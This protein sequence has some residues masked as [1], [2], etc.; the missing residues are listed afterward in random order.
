MSFKRLTTL[1]LMAFCFLTGTFAQRFIVTGTVESGK[2]NRGVEFVT[3]ALL[4]SDSTGVTSAMTNENGTFRLR[5]KSAGSYI[6][7]ISYVGFKTEYR[8]VVLTRQTDSINIGRIPLENSDNLLKEAVVSVTAARVEQQGDTT[9]F[10][11]S[12]Y[13]VPEGSTLEALVEQL[14]G[15]EVD[16][17]GTITWNGKE[18]KEFLVNGK[19]FFKGDTQVAMKNL[20]TDLVSKIKAYDKKSD[21]AEQTGIDDGEETTVLDITTKR[22]LK[23]SWISNVDLGVGTKDRYTDRIFIS[24]FTETSRISAYG[25]ANNVADRGFGSGRRG[26]GGGNGLTASKSAGMD[27]YW[28]NGKE[29]REA[30]RLELGGNVRYSH[31]GTDA[32]SATSSQTFLTANSK[33]SF[34]N[35]RSFN[36]SSSNS[37]NGSFRVQWSPDS[38]T[39][40]TF[41]PSYSHS[42]SKSSGESASATFNGDP[43][44]IPGMYS[45]IDSILLDDVAN[46]NPKLAAIAVNSNLRHSLSDSKSDNVSGSLNI[47]RRLNSDGRNV[48][49]RA[50]A[51]YSESESSSHSMS[52][53]RYY[54]S[55][56]PA[57]NLHQYSF[58]PSKNWNYNVRVG[59]TEP[60]GNNWFGEVRYE[61]GYKYNDAN[62]SRYNLDKITD[63]PLGRNWVNDYALF[64]TI[65]SDADL[66]N[67]VR[68][69]YN[70]QYATYKYYDHTVNLGIRYNAGDIRFNAGVKFNPEKTDMAYERPGQNIDTLITRNVN[71]VS[72]TVRFRYR[73]SKTSQLEVRYNG[74]SS[75]PSMT[76]L[77][78][79]VDNADPL[80]ISMGN[81]GLKPSWNNSF[82]VNYNTYN[83]TA[84]RGIMTG[85]NFS[86]TSNSVSNRMVYDETTGVRY[87]RPENISGN[88]N[89]RANFMLNTGIG[90]KKTFTVSTA[91]NLSYSNS[92]GYIS[93]V[94]NG[95]SLS[96]YIDGTYNGYNNLFNNATSEKN[97]TRSLTVFER[98]NANY[99]LSIFDVGLNG[100]VRYQHARATLLDNA[101]MDTWNFSYGGNANLNLDFGLSLSTDIR[102]SS[103][104]GYSSASMN[105]NELIWNAQIS[106]SF[107]KGRAATISLQF[108]DILHNQSNVSRTLTATM[109][110]DSW[111][112]SI[113]SYVMI[114]FIYRLNIFSGSGNKRSGGEERR[115]P[116]RMMGA[117]M[118]PPP[119]GG[120]F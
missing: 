57:S 101:N 1:L 72:P 117:P 17:N 51:G 86:Q 82:D 114:H 112:N 116:M 105:T 53:I 98:L 61:Y 33:P 93:S 4:K 46:I 39:K 80:N 59:Y 120:H 40:I 31:S 47:V 11:A 8:N 25:S 32:L 50:S 110:S 41:R 118:G 45:P 35:S 65:P 44:S 34:S 103:R 97:T 79:V 9:V 27:F 3:A 23:G 29:K 104:R 78:A 10:N 81:P 58:M 75:Q 28:E 63:D 15:V 89:A 84:Q 113:N 73:F 90:A 70:S 18:V 67:A 37:F 60:L 106:Q 88:W 49:L 36:R 94:N 24:N 64:G 77:L 66:L 115:E 71:K 85:F 48:S 20:P 108:Y 26:Y 95:S 68:D 22:K 19:D 99:R 16:D 92:V 6:V 100:T 7:K 74:S 109:R 62:R 76:N 13:R 87:T 119:G 54:N 43:D 96:S 21:Y 107:L 2:T 83:T 12:A 30:G 56:K 42:D 91:T 14:P 69:E 5:A 102:M 38:L 111:N 55:G 52:S